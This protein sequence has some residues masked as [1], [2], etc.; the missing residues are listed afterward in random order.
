MDIDIIERLALAIAI[1]AI[2]GVERHWRERDEMAGART[3]GLRTFT[4]IGMTGGVA[5]LIAGSAR[6]SDL[7][8]AILIAGVFAV[9]SSVVATFQYREQVVEEDFSVTSVIAAM[10]TFLLGVVAL[11][12]DKSLASAGSV[13]LVS[14]LAS[15][16]FL[17]GF[18][19][20][21]SPSRGRTLTFEISRY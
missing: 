8:V 5:G 19:R 2:V 7:A 13:I 21:L 1:G 16:E 17:H 3:A 6:L 12:G 20:R 14:V 9:L 11:V 15:R 10:L 18:M 4:L